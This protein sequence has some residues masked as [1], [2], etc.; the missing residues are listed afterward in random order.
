M[1]YYKIVSCKPVSIGASPEVVAKRWL[2]CLADSDVLRR[3]VGT[4]I[5]SDPHGR[6]R[7]SI[8]EYERIRSD[9]SFS[10]AHEGKLRTT[11]LLQEEAKS[12]L[13]FSLVYDVEGY[14]LEVEGNFNSYTSLSDFGF[15]APIVP[16]GWWVN[17][18]PCG[19]K[20]E[21]IDEERLLFRL[22][23]EDGQWEAEF[24]DLSFQSDWAQSSQFDGTNA[25]IVEALHDLSEAA[26][27]AVMAENV[28]ELNDDGKARLR[29]RLDTVM[30]I[31]EHLE[32]LTRLQEDG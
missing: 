27:E 12:W 24:A 10:G 11:Q 13:G 19:I 8:K 21:H 15:L 2:E 4:R 23:A 28:G 18:R 26:A 7:P 3:K 32:A 17:V 6:L 1:S 30:G 16:E 29:I 5:T 9:A 14:L 31:I 22:V 25:V 20:A